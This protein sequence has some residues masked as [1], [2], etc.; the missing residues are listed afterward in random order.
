MHVSQPQHRPPQDL[1]SPMLQIAT[2]CSHG[3]CRF[4]NIFEGVPF[5]MSSMSE[6]IEDVD[7]IAATAMKTTRR[8]YLTGGN[9]F[10]LPNRRLVEV[11]DAVEARMP[12]VNSYGGFCRI[13]DVVLQARRLREAGIE[14]TFFYLVGMAG[15][16]TAVRKAGAAARESG[17]ESRG[18]ASGCAGRESGRAERIARR[19]AD[20]AR[21]T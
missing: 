3:K 16:G 19:S 10:A 15:A 7:E 17:S 4:C 21:R 9:P 12:Q 1:G 14:F 13:V 20:E 6:I 5:A 11:F 18:R 2:G 8:I